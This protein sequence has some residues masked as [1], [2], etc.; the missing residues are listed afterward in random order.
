MT[1]NREELESRILQILGYIKNE[2]LLAL[3]RENPNIF[4]DEDL[5]LVLNFLETGENN[6]L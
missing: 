4:S 1:K 6:F 5:V 3:F 2:E